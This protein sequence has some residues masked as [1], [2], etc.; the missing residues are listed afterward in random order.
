MK[1]LLLLLLILAPL[2]S[3]GLAASER[4]NTV[5]I[6]P[7]ETIYA[8]F[9]QKGKKLKLLEATKEKDAKAQ[10]ILTATQ[11]EK[12]KFIT[13]KLENSFAKDL[14]YK[15]EMRSVKFK[16]HTAATVY[17][18]VGGKMGTVDFPPMVDEIALYEFQLDPERPVQAD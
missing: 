4:A 13:L 1:R 5:L 8:R 3:I 12:T 14:L 15:A 9:E 18:V 16:R 6:H 10:L 7:G 11:N 17:P 2:G